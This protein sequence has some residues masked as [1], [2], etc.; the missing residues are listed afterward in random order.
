MSKAWT[1]NL[2]RRSVSNCRGCYDGRRR[3][4]NAVPANAKMMDIQEACDSVTREFI[5]LTAMVHKIW[6][7][8]VK[9]GDVAVDATA[10]RGRDTLGLAKLLLKREK[11]VL[12]S[13]DKQLSPLVHAFDIQTEAIDSTRKLLESSLSPKDA[14]RVVLH[15]C[16]HAELETRLG[17][18]GVTKG[19][20]GV[21]CF[22]LGY[23]PGS[24]QTIVTKPEST[25]AGID[26][27]TCFIRPGGI[28]SLAAYVGHDEGQGEYNRVRQRCHDLVGCDAS[29]WSIAEFD[30]FLEGRAPASCPKLI[31]LQRRAL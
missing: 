25:L 23:L 27:S 20:V 26:A 1:R 4:S 16:S 17:E 18:R 11:P 31:F 7:I 24:D 30:P 10:G 21:I 2:F 19:S 5:P 8:H 22:N 14:A 3:S 28:I 6:S 15:Q 29:V 12:P 13:T 9:S